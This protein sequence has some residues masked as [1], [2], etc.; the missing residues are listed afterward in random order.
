MVLN[1][2]YPYLYV[3]GILVAISPEVHFYENYEIHAYLPMQQS[4]KISAIPQYEHRVCVGF[5]STWNLLVLGAVE[6]P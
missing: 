5:G 3:S 6:M 1:Y 4:E 2:V